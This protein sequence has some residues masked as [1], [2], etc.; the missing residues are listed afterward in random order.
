[1][2][3]Q[4]VNPHV[5]S[6]SVIGLSVALTAICS[7]ISLPIGA[8]PFTLQTFAIFIIAGL[9]DLKT[10]LLSFLAYLL[11]GG[12]GVPVFANFK[13]G[14][15]VLQGPTG[16]YLIG[17]FMTII[18]VWLFKQIKVHQTVFMVIGMVVGLAV[19]YAVGTIWFYKVYTGGEAMGIMS[20][21]SMCVIP[22]VIPD[23]AKLAIASII[24]IRLRKPLESI[25]YKYNGTGFAFS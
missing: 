13:S 4:K 3:K 23:L 14:F 20:I 22:F 8:V 5:L 15:A 24:I 9:F 2:S 21:L 7:W 10:G 25:G 16:G 19:C 11:L 1:M 17:F 18:I 12:V 6:I